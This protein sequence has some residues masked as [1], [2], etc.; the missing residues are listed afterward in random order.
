MRCKGRRP[1]RGRSSLQSA[2]QRRYNVNNINIFTPVTLFCT[3][4]TKHPSMV[5]LPLSVRSSFSNYVVVIFTMN[6]ATPSIKRRNLSP[7]M[8][9]RKALTTST[10][11]PVH[12]LD[13]CLAKPCSSLFSS[14][15]GSSFHRGSD[16]TT[17]LSYTNYISEHAVEDK[18]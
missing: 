16:C 6:S 9:S 5:T 8:L 10:L 18:A 4:N 14:L 17:N 7:R 15:S 11:L 2:I 3:S 1:E 12:R 13:S